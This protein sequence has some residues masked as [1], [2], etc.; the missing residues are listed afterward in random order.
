[1]GPPG[2]VPITWIAN[3]GKRLRPGRPHLPQLISHPSPTSLARPH[4]SLPDSTRNSTYNL[5]SLHHSFGLCSSSC[6]SKSRILARAKNN[7]GW[8][9]D[10]GEAFF[11]QRLQHRWAA[12]FFIAFVERQQV[13][14]RAQGVDQAHRLPPDC[15]ESGGYPVPSLPAASGKAG[16]ED[17]SSHSKT[18]LVVVLPAQC[19]HR[20]RARRL[21]LRVPRA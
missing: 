4:P 21:Q 20:S 5:H 2:G 8:S 11:L 16:D 14:N 15:F 17:L 1:M 6:C 3:Y 10:K 9:M 19:E 18:Q 13:G 7:R 12:A